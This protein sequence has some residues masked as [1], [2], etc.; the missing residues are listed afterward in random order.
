MEITGYPNGGDFPATF[1]MPGTPGVTSSL[2]NIAAWLDGYIVFTNAGF[3]EMG[4]NSDDGF[5]VSENYGLKRQILH[6]TGPG[7]INTDVGAVVSDTTYG[8]GGFGAVPPQTPVSGPVFFVNSNNY[9]VGS[10]INL[11]GKVAVVDRG[12][13]GAD[14]HTLCAVAQTNGA[15]AAVTIN[16]PAGTNSPAGMP[17]LM[18]GGTPLLIPCMEVNGSYGQRDFWIT[19]QNLVASVGASYGAVLGGADFGRGDTHTD[20]GFVVPTAGAYPIHLT[21]FQGGGGANF[22]WTVLTGG[23]AAD[24]TRSLLNDVTNGLSLISYQAAVANLSVEPTVSVGIQSGSVVITFTGKLQSST[25]VN[26]TYSDVPGAASPYT[27]PVSGA[28]PAQ[29]YRSH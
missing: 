11:T 27:V 24:G 21:Y 1:T 28:A 5:R 19:N 7:G 2:N 10:S 8:N 23:V 6:V 4:V 20:F 15:I 9:T 26:G 13:Y 17:G 18:T 12:L 25:T 14:D 3:Y 29:F 16:T 22:E